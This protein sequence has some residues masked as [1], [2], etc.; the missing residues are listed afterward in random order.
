MGDVERYN[1]DWNDDKNLNISILYKFIEF[2]K[3][4]Q[5]HKILVFLIQS[6]QLT[7]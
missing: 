4:N 7:N 1:F 3:N 5:F 6:E 2:S